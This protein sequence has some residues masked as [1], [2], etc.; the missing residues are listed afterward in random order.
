MTKFTLGFRLLLILPP[1]LRVPTPRRRR[2][3]QSPPPLPP[4]PRRPRPPPLPHRPPQPPRVIRSISPHIAS[5]P[6][7][8]SSKILDFAAKWHLIYDELRLCEGSCAPS[9]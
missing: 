5:Q 4:H 1:I 9:A 6:S 7:A 3:Q 2:R 8:S